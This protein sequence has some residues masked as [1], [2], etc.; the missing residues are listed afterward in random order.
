MAWSSVSQSHSS[1]DLVDAHAVCR[2]SSTS[3][4]YSRSVSMRRPNMSSGLVQ[5]LPST[6]LTALSVAFL[7]RY[8]NSF[9]ACHYITVAPDCA[10]NILEIWDV[11]GLGSFF[12][13]QPF[14]TRDALNISWGSEL[15]LGVASLKSSFGV[16]AGGLS[17]HLAKLDGLGCR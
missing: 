5:P 7:V 4:S 10:L 2:S 14:Y 9:P 8:L 12:L 3:A 11:L 16:C 1:L 17:G 15:D 13:L 6:T